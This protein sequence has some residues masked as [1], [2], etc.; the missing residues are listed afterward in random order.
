[1]LDHNGNYALVFNTSGMY[2][3]V[4]TADGKMDVQIYK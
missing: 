4:V 3:G 2:R 1:V